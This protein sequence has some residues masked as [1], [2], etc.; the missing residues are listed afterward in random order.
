[1]AFEIETP[2]GN[3]GPTGAAISF[4]EQGWDFFEDK[5]I[6]FSNKA[7]ELISQLGYVP[8][9]Q[10]TYFSVNFPDVTGL[11]A[12]ETP[13]RPVL[14]QIAFNDIT[15]PEPPIDATTL[16]PMPGFTESPAFD[17]A[18]PAPVSLPVQPGSLNAEDPGP[19]PTL[20]PLVM[21]LSPTLPDLPA[22]F[23]IVINEIGALPEFAG[24]DPGDAPQLPDLSSVGFTEVPYVPALLNDMTPVI[25]RG[26][27][28]GQILD[29]AIEQ[30]L[31]QRSRERIGKSNRQAR[32]AIDEEFSGRGFK[33]PPG[34]WG[35]RHM[36][37]AHQNQDQVADVNRD[38]TIQFHTEAIKNVQFA[39]VQGI[40]LEQVLI[41]QHS[42][43]MDRSLQSA[44][45]LLDTHVALHNADVACYNAKI[46]RF[47]A[48]AAV[49][50][51]RLSAAVEAYKAH[52]E[53]QKAK[54]DVNRALA[55]V[56]ESQVSA[57]IEQYKAAV[58]AVQA[59]AEIE[60]AR[61]EGYRATVQAFGE[62]VNAHKVE[63]DG[64]TAAVNAQQ[65]GF[66]N[67]EIGVNAYSARVTAWAEGERAKSA[68]YDTQ[69]KGATNVLEAYR[70]RVQG[71]L[72]RLQVERGRI[73]AV[74]AQ[75]DALAR[76]YQAD[77]AIETARNDANTRAFQAAVAYNE[78][79][80]NIQLREAE[81]KIQDAARLLTA[82]VEA[83]RGAAAALAQLA[84]S[85]MSAVNFSAAVSGSGSESSN[86][87]YALSKSKSWN[88]SGETPDDLSPD[89]W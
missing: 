40:A 59:Q 67:Y 32:Q 9:V 4:V 11:T 8:Q 22:F 35:A 3:I 57:I 13:D 84:A 44:R 37:Q 17:V 78:T 72:A 62:R 38:L 75:T 70:A 63:W 56:F 7:L 71:V 47:K 73:D 58:A 77:G 61:I 88:W 25:R 54:A 86:Y 24:Q 51:E 87:S 34:A 36:E 42:A 89:T 82:Q 15:V 31:F 41:G 80:A 69:L 2:G 53:G 68:R 28:S 81:I 83:V 66:R 12:F 30:A 6:L 21:P 27:A 23:D 10:P 33:L 65:A 39:I 79:R 74:T 60:K 14:P 45:L 26:L 18:P 1:M 55:D 50:R 64:Y 76:M 20:S 85:A 52:I 5:A 48:D 16:P 46:E 49:F 19:A 29:A 43:M